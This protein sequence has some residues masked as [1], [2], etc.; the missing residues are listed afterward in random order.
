M[1]G[2]V[3][4]QHCHTAPLFLYEYIKN[5]MVS[6]TNPVSCCNTCPPAHGNISVTFYYGCVKSV[7][8]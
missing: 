4:V 1:C 8:P 7:A 2:F 6:F 5:I 3:D